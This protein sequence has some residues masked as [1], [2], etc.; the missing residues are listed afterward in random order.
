MRIGRRLARACGAC[1]E[2]ANVLAVYRA[3]DDT[4]TAY[5]R[6]STLTCGDGSPLL[7][8]SNVRLG[9]ACYRRVGQIDEADLPGGATVYQNMAMECAPSCG[10]VACDTT[11]Y[12][13]LSPCR[14]FDANCGTGTL[15]YAAASAMQGQSFVSIPGVGTFCATGETL[16]RWQIAV[17]GTLIVNPLA[18]TFGADCCDAACVAQGGGTP[19]NSVNGRRCCNSVGSTPNC[20]VYGTA[21]EVRRTLSGGSVID[22]TRT[23][24]Y[25]GKTAT[26]VVEVYR[27]GQLDPNE[28]YT[29]TFG[30]PCVG[31]I[32][33]SQ[34]GGAC[35]VPYSDAFVPGWQLDGC[36]TAMACGSGRSL[37]GTRTRSCS[38]SSYSWSYLCNNTCDGGPCPGGNHFFINQAGA[39][40]IVHPVSV[41]GST[42]CGCCGVAPGTYPDPATLKI[43]GEVER[44]EVTRWLGLEWYGTPKP[45]RWL[46]IGKKD[47]GCGC[48]KPLKDAWNRISGATL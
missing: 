1:C 42:D 2:P 30:V 11:L 22:T 39:L 32:Y 27:D 4:A 37:T 31:P 45:L 12:V 9:G 23:I 41:N 35:W 28:S 38:V 7:P 34:A 26:D 13:R 14:V 15:Y 29:S 47:P 19:S 8:S 36:A 33:D 18:G 48:V 17:S 10:D 21:S 16:Q 46:G 40:T 5:L 44:G 25:A 6:T 3:C 20:G 24:T 43:P